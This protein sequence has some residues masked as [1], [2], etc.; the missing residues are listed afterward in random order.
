MLG[1]YL[2]LLNLICLEQNRNLGD[3]GDS[4][5]VLQFR[6]LQALLRLLL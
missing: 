3:W 5:L 1:N 6:E 2:C 4:H